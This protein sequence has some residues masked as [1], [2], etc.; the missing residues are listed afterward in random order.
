MNLN[1]SS[2]AMTILLALGMFVAGVQSRVWQLSAVG[3]V[4]FLAAP[5]LGW[6]DQSSL[7]VTAVAFAIIVLGGIVWWIRHRPSRAQAVAPLDEASR[8]R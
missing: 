6:L 2:L 1:A 7:L 3:G 8:S 4:L 5:G